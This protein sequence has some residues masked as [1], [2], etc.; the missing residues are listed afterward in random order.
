MGE[1]TNGMKTS[2]EELER[3]VESI[4]EG[5]APILSELDHRRH[6]LTDWRHQLR[7][8]GPILLKS[9][10]VVAGLVT[11]AKLVQR[12]GRKRRARRGAAV[13]SIW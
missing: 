1:R 11:V 10:A 5:M 4:R 13:S 9:L 7:Q 12:R 6:D 8:R 3:E 2:P